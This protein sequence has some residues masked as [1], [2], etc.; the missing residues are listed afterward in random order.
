MAEESGWLIERGDSETSAPLY[1]APQTDS[2]WDKSHE[3]ACRFARKQDAKAVADA[4]G[5]A[6]EHGI[7]ICEH[8]WG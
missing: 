3:L 8:G 5:L 7:R 1:F 4:Y 2:G 6:D